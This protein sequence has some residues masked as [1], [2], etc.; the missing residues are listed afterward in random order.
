M[1][2]DQKNNNGSTEFL[3]FSDALNYLRWGERIARRT[4]KP[5]SYLKANYTGG[6]SRIEL[7][8]KRISSWPVEWRD[9][10]EDLLAEDWYVLG[11]H[12]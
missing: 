11:E 2:L 5:D 10:C 8:V 3:N 4:W 1:N 12:Q 6:R 7:F 9:N